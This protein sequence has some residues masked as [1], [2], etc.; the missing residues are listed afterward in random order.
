MTDAIEAKIKAKYAWT[1][2]DDKAIQEYNEKVSA[3]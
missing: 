1:E 3:I 2:A